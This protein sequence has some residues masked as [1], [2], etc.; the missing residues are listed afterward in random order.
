MFARIVT[1][2]FLSVATV[3]GTLAVNGGAALAQTSAAAVTAPLPPAKPADTEQSKEPAH[4][5]Q[6]DL[7]QKEKTQS[8][9]QLFGS[10]QLP[11]IG[12]AVSIG[13][14]PRGC[15]AG[16]VEFPVTGSTWQV[17]RLSR[18][19]NWGHPKLIQFLE[20]FAPLA[21]KTTGWN[22]ILVGDLA[23]PR[24][25]PLPYG[26]MSHQIGLDV[27]IWFMTIPD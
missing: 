11:S 10:V 25:G 18:N 2:F 8:A 27:D 12:K 3:A 4:A 6:K 15:L 16:G 26:H 23:Q 1:P 17:M 13:Y 14:Y 7:T 22:G 9:K 21:A 5:E 19:R 24:G 20:K